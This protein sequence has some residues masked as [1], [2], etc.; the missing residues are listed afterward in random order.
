M[1]QW[2]TL[3]FRRFLA[4]IIPVMLARLIHEKISYLLLL[5]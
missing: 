3:I 1:A 5:P 2:P 4:M